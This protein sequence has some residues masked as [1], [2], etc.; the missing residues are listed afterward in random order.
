M[1]FHPRAADAGAPTDTRSSADGPSFVEF[2]G[3]FKGRNKL[4]RCYL[5]QEGGS[6]VATLDNIV[7]DWSR[8]G[9]CPC[10]DAYAAG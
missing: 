2:G 3:F 4:P 5:Q 6:T 9:F 1:T 10:G 7:V 8:R